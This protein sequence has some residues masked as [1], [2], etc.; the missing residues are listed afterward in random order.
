MHVYIHVMPVGCLNKRTIDALISSS[1]KK[2]NKI[3]PEDCFTKQNLKGKDDKLQMVPNPL[4][5]A[6]RVQSPIHVN[7][8]NKVKSNSMDL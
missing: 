1:K 3:Y 7:Q 6:K 4:H 8:N 2:T 5:S